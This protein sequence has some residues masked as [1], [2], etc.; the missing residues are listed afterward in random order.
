MWWIFVLGMMVG[1][2]LVAG[3][4][5]LLTWLYP[6]PNWALASQICE[7]HGRGNILTLRSDVIV[8]LDTMV[9]DRDMVIRSNEE[10]IKGLRELCSQQTT[11]LIETQD[12]LDAMTAKTKA[13]HDLLWEKTGEANAILRDLMLSYSNDSV[14]TKES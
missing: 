5:S 14:Q 2:G 6:D 7:K 10:T 8:L 9:Q 13:A 12:K 4:L 3:T 11:A 1:L